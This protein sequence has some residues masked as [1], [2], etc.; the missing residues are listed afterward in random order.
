MGTLIDTSVLIEVERNRLDLSKYVAPSSNDYFIS[1]ITVSELLH[2]LHRTTASSM[3][4]R[5]KAFI[6][7][8]LEQF[9]ILDI[10]IDIAQKHAQIWAELARAGKIIGMNDLWLAATCL[11]R[12]LKLV[13]YNVREFERV[14]GLDFEIW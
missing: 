10:D 14:A 12:H 5:R 2:G 9:P 4:S 13:T 1:V 11:S 7:D 6:E 8:V 3:H